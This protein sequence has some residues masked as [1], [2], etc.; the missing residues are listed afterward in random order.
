LLIKIS[1]YSAKHGGDFGFWSLLISAF[2]DRSGVS[3]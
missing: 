1:R 2:A 3:P